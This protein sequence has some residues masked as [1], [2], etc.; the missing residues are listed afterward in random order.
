VL[1]ALAPLHFEAQKPPFSPLR[2]LMA[3]PMMVSI[4]VCVQVCMYVRINKQLYVAGHG[5]HAGGGAGHA[6]AAAG[7]ESRGALT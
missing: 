2:M 7:N 6:E 1:T 5:L 3:N 4:Y